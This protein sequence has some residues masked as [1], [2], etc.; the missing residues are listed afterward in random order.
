[1]CAAMSFFS[2]Y[3]ERT[4]KVTAQYKFFMPENM[5]V[6]EGKRTA[7]TR[8]K[9]ESI[10]EHFGSQVTQD[11]TTHVS[12]VNGESQVKF[13]SRGGSKVCGEWIETSGSPKYDITY[14]DGMTVIYVEV[15][16]KIRQIDREVID[17]SVKVLKNSTDERHESYDFKNGDDVYLSFSSPIDGYVAVYLVDANATAFCLLPYGRQKNIYKVEGN[18][19]YIFGDSDSADPYEKALVDNYIMTTDMTHENNYFYVIFSPNEFTKALDN[20]TDTALPRNL[21]EDGF[22]NWLEKLRSHDKR[23]QEIILPVS[24]NR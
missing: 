13:E 24:V 15:K 8:A 6:E 3:A 2:V 4:E 21:S 17:L 12:N 7:L 22:L 20:Q 10:A 5:T 9:Q 14:E 16:G 18:K 11:N 23:M 19:K 1:M